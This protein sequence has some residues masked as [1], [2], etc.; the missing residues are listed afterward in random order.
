[1]LQ[2]IA[3]V[4][5]GA[6][7]LYYPAITSTQVDGNGYIE[8]FVQRKGLV[9]AATAIGKAN[10]LARECN[11]DGSDACA[12]NNPDYHEYLLKVIIPH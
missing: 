7:P 1:M 8:S 2:F 5:I 12:L 6:G 9:H 10:H 4:V 3:S 11:H